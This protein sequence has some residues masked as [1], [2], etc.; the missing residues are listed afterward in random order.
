MTE[1]EYFN[2]GK[3]LNIA[4][5]EIGETEHPAGSNLCKYNR[6]FYGK[7]SGGAW[8]ATF[9]M[10]V[11]DQAGI[12]FPMADWRRGYASVPNLKKARKDEITKEPMGGDLVIF[13]FNGK[14]LPDH[15]GIFEK[16]EEEGKTFWCIEG[17]TSDKG[18]QSNGGAVLRKL[19][20]VKLVDCFI[21]PR[22]LR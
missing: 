20:G 1:Q 18:S 7:D 17:N 22:E 11:Y 10:W 21:S 4:A 6:W 16:W 8:C 19:R 14:P 12:P 5:A 13:E 2:R 3:L 15:I 9:I